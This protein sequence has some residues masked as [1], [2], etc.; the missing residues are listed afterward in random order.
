VSG[1]DTVEAAVVAA[2]V[3]RVT[4]VLPPELGVS[5]R[6]AGDMIEIVE[7]GRPCGSFGAAG[8]PESVADMLLSSVQDIVSETLT[9]PWP[10]DPRRPTAMQLPGAAIRDVSLHLWYGDESCPALAL[11]PIPLAELEP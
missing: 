5:F 8:D 3:P 11:D 9:M 10:P 1:E 4:A 2:L 7:N 6:A